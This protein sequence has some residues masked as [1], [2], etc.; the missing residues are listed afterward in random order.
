MKTQYTRITLKRSGDNERGNG[1]DDD[2]IF[3]KCKVS[4]LCIFY[5]YLLF[6]DDAPSWISKC[7]PKG[8]ESD[9]G[10]FQPD[11]VSIEAAQSVATT[12]SRKRSASASFDTRFDKIE[13]ML[14]SS[15]EPPVNA[16]P[17]TAAYVEQLQQDMS[18]SAFNFLPLDLQAQLVD[19][20]SQR[21]GFLLLVV[22]TDCAAS[23]ET[24]SGWKTPTSD[25]RP[26]G[27]HFDIHEG[28]LSL[29]KRYM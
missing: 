5:M 17:G 26:F 2:Y 18:C 23:M 12:K 7:L 25:S 28:A 27:K 8:L 3:E 15:Y 13:S 20:M 19:A 24:S 9:V 14:Q 6:K 22:A 29:N 11:E 10:V 16:K 1:E 21:Y 4:E